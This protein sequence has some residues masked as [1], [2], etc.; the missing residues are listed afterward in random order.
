[1]KPLEALNAIKNEIVATLGQDQECGGWRIGKPILI[2]TLETV[3]T[4]AETSL[5]N[6]DTVI[7]TTPKEGAD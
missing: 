6:A 5:Q 2:E 4:L 1:M 7:I 3:L